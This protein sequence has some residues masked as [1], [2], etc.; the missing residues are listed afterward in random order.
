MLGRRPF[1]YE[2][3]HPGTAFVV[4]KGARDHAR[5]EVIGP[6][7]SEVHLLIE[8][9]LARGEGFRRLFRKLSGKAHDFG[10]ESIRGNDTVH[11]A[12]FQ[13]FL[14]IDRVCGQEQLHGALAQQVA[15]HRDTGGRAEKAPADSRGG[16]LRRL[17]GHRQVALRDELAA[18][19]GRRALHA[20]NDRLRQ[21][22]DR[23][24]HPAALREQ[25]LDLRLLLERA[26]FFQIMAG[27]KAFSCSSQHHHTYFLI[28]NQRI[29]SG[30]KCVQHLARQQVHLLRAVHG[31]RAD[32]VALIAQQERLS[33]LRNGTHVSMALVDFAFSRSRNFW[34][35]PVEVFGSSPNTTAR[36]ALN[37][38]RWPRQNSMI[39]ISEALASGFSST[40]AHGVS[41]H[42]ASGFATTAAA[43]TAGWRYRM[44]S[45]SS[46]EMFSPPEM[47]MSFERSL[48]LT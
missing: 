18:G 33:G 17:R 21:R 22:G 11:Q 8:G 7:H 23:L 26:D 16:E 10:V 2:S 3:I 32:G 29:K 1:L 9:A 46:E 44:S 14:R 36:G 34:I 20:R 45:T 24:H 41:P 47:M 39:S 38:A 35:L 6:G 12:P 42:F 13:R 4:G 25:L 5:G 43:S 30:L 37:L 31:Q 27:A 15:A 48:I 19:R 40:K 28:R